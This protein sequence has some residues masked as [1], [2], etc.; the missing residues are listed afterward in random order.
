MPE[1]TDHTVRTLIAAAGLSPSEEEMAILIAGYPAFKEGIEALYA[2]PETRYA[3]PALVF[4][5]T[6][7]FADWAV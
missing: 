7:T 4:S 3:A 6:P 2:V 1:D 5:A